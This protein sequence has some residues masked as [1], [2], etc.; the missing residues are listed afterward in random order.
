MSHIPTSEM[1]RCHNKYVLDLIKYGI[2]SY[3]KGDT[4]THTDP[5]T[6]Q[7]QLLLS[8]DSI[9]PR[10][11][12]S[13]STMLTLLYRAYSLIFPTRKLIGGLGGQAWS[14]HTYMTLPAPRVF[15]PSLVPFMLQPTTGLLHKLFSA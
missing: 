7:P 2:Y 8:E 11:L 1:L 6:Q 9:S 4:Q 13:P 15:F 10:H 14:P 5:P 12:V 3:E